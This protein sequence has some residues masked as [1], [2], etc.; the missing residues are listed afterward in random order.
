MAGE[1]I[2]SDWSV[3]CRKLDE[4]QHF[5]NESNMPRNDENNQR[6]HHQSSDHFVT[7]M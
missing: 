4:P 1:N 2:E 6:V 5:L 3:V 7:M